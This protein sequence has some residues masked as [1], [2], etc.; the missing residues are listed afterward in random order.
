MNNVTKND[1][2]HG[3]FEAVRPQLINFSVTIHFF[4]ILY[5][6]SLNS[7]NFLYMEATEKLRIFLDSEIH[8]LAFIFYTFVSE[9]SPKTNM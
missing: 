8:F 1:E 2:D 9:I 3:I 7:S 6:K 4:E 5:S